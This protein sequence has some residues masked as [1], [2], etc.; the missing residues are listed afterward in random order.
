MLPESCYFILDKC[1]DTDNKFSNWELGFFGQIRVQASPCGFYAN[2]Q[3]TSWMQH[4]RGIFLTLRLCC[5]WSRGHLRGVI[6]GLQGRCTMKYP[7]WMPPSCLEFQHCGLQ[8]TFEASLF[9]ECTTTLPLNHSLQLTP[10]F[11]L[12]YQLAPIGHSYP[13]IRSRET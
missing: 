8:V 7:S 6:W 1:V 4:P 9:I 12:F 11:T 2:R 10:G 5:A 3:C 13:W